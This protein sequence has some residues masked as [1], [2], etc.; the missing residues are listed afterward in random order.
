LGFV[1]ATVAYK[2][3]ISKMK[4][5]AST[6]TAIYAGDVINLAEFEKALFESCRAVEDSLRGF[7]KIKLNSRTREK[8][9]I[10]HSDNQVFSYIARYLIERFD[11]S[12]N[13]SPR[14]VDRSGE[15]LKNI[16]LFYLIDILNGTWSG[17]GDSR[18]YR[19]TW[20]GTG[21]AA[22]PAPDYLNPPSISEWDS[23]LESWHNRELSKLQKE[24]TGNTPEAKLLLK[25]LYQDVMTVVQNETFTFDIEH[26]WSVDKLKSLISASGSDGWPIGAFSNL[27]LLQ[28]E[29]NQTKGSVML[30][31]YKTSEAGLALEP[32]VWDQIQKFV[33]WPNLDNLKFESDLTKESYIKFCKERFVELK[34]I[35]LK[36]V[37]FNE[38][39]QREYYNQ[40]GN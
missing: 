38:L 18:L 5:L 31:D 9:F 4:D 28:K 24:R 25:F 15:L 6:L 3:P 16:P 34:K 32:R 21:D 2:L 40:S 12:N 23:T 8:Q 36:D 20:T 27:A 10:P 7:L 26:L 14:N 33:I 37:G 17:S 30:G 1:L 11:P 29:I 39:S 35:L 13:W 19:V 22:T